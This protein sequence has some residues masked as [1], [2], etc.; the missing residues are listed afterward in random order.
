MSYKFSDIDKFRDW[1]MMFSEEISEDDP[2]NI[3]VY[4][5]FQD[6]ASG[7]KLGDGTN[8]SFIYGDENLPDLYT[9]VDTTVTAGQTTI[10]I[11]EK[12][13]VDLQSPPG[14]FWKY[15]KNIEKCLN[16]IFCSKCCPENI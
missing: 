15:S 14:N 2:L 8:Y 3:R 11:D 12:D 10:N 4:Q 6:L 7:E 9:F 16:R 5:A 1:I 13:E